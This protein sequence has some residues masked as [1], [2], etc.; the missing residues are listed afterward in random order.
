M[1]Q[2]I[3]SSTRSFDLCLPTGN[4][5][6]SI[7]AFIYYSPTISR[8][9]VGNLR[10]HHKSLRG[11]LHSEPVHCLSLFAEQPYLPYHSWSHLAM[12]IAGQIWLCPFRQS[13]DCRSLSEPQSGFLYCST[14]SQA[15]TINQVWVI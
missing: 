8:P 2:F 3:L 14:L 10:V 4:Q 6:S 1:Q 11:P 12:F 15:V 5:H 7:T 13:S 9:C